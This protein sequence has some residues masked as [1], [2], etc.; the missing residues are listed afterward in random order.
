ME[1]KIINHFQEKV[2]ILEGKTIRGNIIY[3]SHFSPEEALHLADK[4]N[5][6]LKTREAALNLRNAI[7]DA[8]VACLSKEL[9][10][11]DIYKRETDIPDLLK[12]FIS[13]LISGPDIKR[14]NT[15]SKI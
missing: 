7:K 4:K 6:K 5:M 8:D 10:V 14:N 15:T 3:S 12:T 11:E 13:Y 9:T 1:D 2:K